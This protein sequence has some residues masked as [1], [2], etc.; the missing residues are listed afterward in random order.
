MKKKIYEILRKQV[1]RMA[2]YKLGKIEI[3]D[4][5]I[6]CYV[7]GRK[8]KKK[9]K[10][11]HRYNL[12]F[13]MV[14]PLKELY[15]I[16]RVYKPVH[17]IV[18]NVDFDMEVNIQTSTRNCHVTFENCSFTSGIGMDFA[19][20]ITFKN[21]TYKA[22]DYKDY[23][24]LVPE[25]K[26]YISTKANK[27]EVNQ[28]A[29]LNDK[30][31]VEDT[32]IIPVVRATD[33]NKKPFPK[34]TKESTIEIW[35]YGKEITLIASEIVNAKKIEIGTDKLNLNYANISA[36]EIEIDAKNIESYHCETTSDVIS[37]NADHCVGQIK[38]NHNGM[39]VNGVEVNKHENGINTSDLELQKQRLELI[40]TFKK[41]E[42]TSEEIIAKEIKKQ[43]LTRVLKK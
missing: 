43:P 29:F 18:K 21:N 32:P 19:D 34:R 16:Y 14:N 12:V 6:I 17:Y 27:N 40:N 20:H 24:S 25:G 3:T 35:L 2:T 39:F 8:L 41:I 1:A 33:I 26:F 13:K 4:D 5:E 11:L 9:E 42:R 22:R 28:I 38:S 10:Y 31:S 23:Y 30:I 7:D 37:I 15:K 36:E